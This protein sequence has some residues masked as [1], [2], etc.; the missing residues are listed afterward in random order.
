[1]Q[2]AE[3]A[4]GD[5]SVLSMLRVN[6]KNGPVPLSAVATIREGS[7]PATIDRLDRERNV[8]VTAELNG[9]PLDSVMKQVKALD[10]MTMLPPG[11]RVLPTGDS[12]AFVELFT[13]FAF[14]M[15][16]GIVSV[17]LVLLLLFHS[18]SQPLTILSAVPLCGGG[19]FGMLLISGYALSVPS[20][21]GLLL[22]TGIATKNSIL[23]VDYAIIG[24]RDLGL[25]RVDAIIDACRKRARPVIMT[26][27]AMGAGM[28]PIALG[29]G[30]DGG[31]RAPLGISVLGGLFTST[32]LSLVVVPAVYLSVARL[33]DRLKRRFGRSRESAAPLPIPTPQS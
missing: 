6:G 7:G 23:I 4:L 20:L 29:I 3:S 31:F 16:F 24:E 28:L 18:A 22:L 1:M 19:A 11:V 9:L 8:T 17:Y 13:G 33:T 12:E 21:I 15:L 30:A 25:S 5:R 26:T 14:A 2:L 32:V 10:A 27:L